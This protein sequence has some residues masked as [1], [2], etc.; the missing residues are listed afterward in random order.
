MT[1][2]DLGANIGVYTLLAASLVGE[3][4]RVYAFEP[5]PDNYALLVKNVEAN[6]YHNVVCRQQAVSDRS[7]E[8]PLF[9]GEYGVSHS[10]ST[11]AAV[12]PGLSRTVATTSLDDFFRGQGWPPV[13]F[14]KMNIEGW[15]CFVIR[16]MKGVLDRSGNLK[17]MLEF[18]PDIISKMG[19]DPEGFIRRLQGDCFTIQIIDETKG[20]LPFNSA[21]LERRDGGNILCERAPSGAD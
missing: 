6:G 12:D 19:V 10:L 16:G 8:A 2:V 13:D 7:G 11:F 15:E 14:I 5:D 21:N 3:Q 1:V 18:Y 20:L 4:G 17:M 9:K